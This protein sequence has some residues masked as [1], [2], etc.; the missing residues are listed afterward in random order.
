MDMSIFAV[1]SVCGRGRELSEAGLVL[2]GVEAGP[3]QLCIVSAN[4]EAGY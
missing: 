2:V 4:S 3:L 1:F